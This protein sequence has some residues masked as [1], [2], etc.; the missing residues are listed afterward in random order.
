MSVLHLQLCELINQK[1]CRGKSRQ[2]SKECCNYLPFNK[3]LTLCEQKRLAL[4]KLQS[5]QTGLTKQK[6]PSISKKSLNFIDFF[7]TDVFFCLVPVCRPVSWVI[8]NFSHF[9][10]FEYLRK[11]VLN[12][13]EG[14]S[15]IYSFKVVHT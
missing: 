14:I 9:A 12:P 6:N 5:P 13:Q 8:R 1:F 2:I 7:L 4:N 10:Q 15:G 3:V 11:Q